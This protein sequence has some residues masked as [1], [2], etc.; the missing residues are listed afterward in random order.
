M[1]ELLG[2]HA[3][4]VVRHADILQTLGKLVPREPDQALP[5]VPCRAGLNRCVVAGGGLSPS[6]E[7][8]V[9]GHA[10]TMASWILVKPIRE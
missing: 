9:Y 7:F 6:G 10:L 2:P 1:P 4:A 3:Q 5:L 8:P